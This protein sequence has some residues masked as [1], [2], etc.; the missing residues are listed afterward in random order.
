MVVVRV[1]GGQLCGNPILGLSKVYI[2]LIGYGRVTVQQMRILV[3][4]LPSVINRQ[5]QFVV[6]MRDS[7]LRVFIETSVYFEMLF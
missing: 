3:K 4:A 6:R 7:S 5:A 1:T 2:T